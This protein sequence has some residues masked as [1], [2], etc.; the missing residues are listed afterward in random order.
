M[1]GEWAIGSVGRA[2]RSHRGGHRFESG[3]AHVHRKGSA[4]WPAP[5]GVS[6]VVRR[7]SS[8]PVA[9]SGP[10]PGRA[11]TKEAAPVPELI[12]LTVDGIATTVEPGTTGT[13]LYSARR[14]VVVA[15]VDGELRDLHLPLAAGS[16][17]EAVTVEEPDGLAVLRHSAAHVLAQAVQEIVP[18]AKLGIGPPI[19]DGLLLRLR[20]GHPV[21]PRGPQGDREGH[22]PDRQG[23]PDLPTLGPHRGRGPQGDARRAVQARADRAEGRPRRGRGGVGRGRPRRAE[24]LPE[25]AW[26]RPGDRAGRLAGPV[27]GAAHPEH[28][29]ARQRVPAD[30]V[31][32]RVLAGER[33]EPAAAARVRHRVA[34]EGRAAR[35]PRA[36]R[37]GGASR[38]PTARHRAGPVLLPRGDRLRAWPCSTPRAA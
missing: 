13:D 37:R 22:G 3:I 33:E 27:P 36:H 5:S 7:A 10:P 24:H 31:G 28:P 25:R 4:C 21:H 14:D 16:V 20:R 8:P 35:L 23:G 2:P 38:P 1:C 11:A 19:T 18:T 30:P 29:P 17:V 9:S 6:Y 12:T 32:G 26:G 15:R 34:D